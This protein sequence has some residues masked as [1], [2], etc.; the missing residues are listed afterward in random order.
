MSLARMKGFMLDNKDGKEGRQ[1]LS[2]GLSREV[3]VDQEAHGWL[4]VS[5]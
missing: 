2:V 5:K 1:S 4:E 3:P